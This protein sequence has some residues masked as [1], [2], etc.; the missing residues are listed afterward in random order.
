[1]V[2]EELHS[3]FNVYTGC[4]VNLG[5]VRYVLPSTPL[6][7]HPCDFLVVLSDY[8]RASVLIQHIYQDMD[9]RSPFLLTYLAN[10]LLVLYLPL[11]QLWIVC[12]LVKPATTGGGISS[13]SGTSSRSNS[14]LIVNQLHEDAFSDDASI[15]DNFMA[16]D[17]EPVVPRAREQFTHWDILRIAAVICPLWF[18]SNCMYNYSLLMTSVSSS[19]IIRYLCTMLGMFY[20]VNCRYRIT[21]IWR[22]HLRCSSRGMRASRASPTARCW[23]FSRAF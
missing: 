4:C 11:W 2:L 17:L 19:T 14:E 18:L 20:R 9:F 16:A 23:G 13:I 7:P 1:M 10:S 12:G 5:R 8:C 6:H 22:V 21:A 3:W 15:D